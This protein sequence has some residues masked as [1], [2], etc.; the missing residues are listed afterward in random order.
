MCGKKNIAMDKLIN[1]SRSQRP[2]RSDE[3]TV[4]KVHPG[5]NT[6]RVMPPIVKTLSPAQKL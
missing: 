4:E 5:N 3:E 2:H 1:G 6:Y